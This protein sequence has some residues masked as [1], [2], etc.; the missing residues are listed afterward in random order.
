MDSPSVTADTVAAVGGRFAAGIPLGATFLARATAA[1]YLTE[2]DTIRVPTRHAIERH[3]ALRR[4]VE[5]LTLRL[6]V[7]FET[8]RATVQAESFPEL[9]RAARLLTE[10]PTLRLEVGGH[11]DAVG[12]QRANQRLSQAR[13]NAVRDYLVAA[14]VEPTRMTARG[15]GESV[16]VASNDDAAGRALNRRVEVRLEGAP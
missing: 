9:D 3:F 6:D 7:L 12:S 5:G 2:E 15:Y 11:T 13:A 8:N 1:G 10:H 16:P 14:G 4:L